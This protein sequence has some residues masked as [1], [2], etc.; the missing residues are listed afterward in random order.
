MR[1]VLGFRK[2]FEMEGELNTLEELTSVEGD[3]RE[4]KL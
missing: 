2:Y 1:K 3:Q 4:N